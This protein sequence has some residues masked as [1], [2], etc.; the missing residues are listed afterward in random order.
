MSLQARPPYANRYS[1]FSF[2]IHNIYSSMWQNS[3]ITLLIMRYSSLCFKLILIH[4]LSVLL[5]VSMVFTQSESDFCFLQIYYCTS[6]LSKS[7]YKPK[8]FDGEKM[9]MSHHLCLSLCKYIPG[10]GIATYL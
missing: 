7:K 9:S 5:S 1:S 3:R 10:L 4:Y 8:N 6:F 2:C